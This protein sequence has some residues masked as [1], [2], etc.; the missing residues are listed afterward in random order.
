MI[1][2]QSILRS[3]CLVGA[4]LVACFLCA[5]AYGAQVDAPSE[6]KQ[7]EVSGEFEGEEASDEDTSDG[8]VVD[9]G[10]MEEDEY[11][12]DSDSYDEEGEPQWSRSQVSVVPVP[13]TVTEASVIDDAGN[14]PWYD[15]SSQSLLPAAV[16]RE[17]QPPTPWSWTWE[18]DSGSGSID[19][20]A[21][22][23]VVQVI[24]WMCLACL[25]VWLVVLWARYLARQDHKPSPAELER[26]RQRHEIDSIE[27]LPFQMAK[28]QSD[29][30]SEAR[31]HY[32]Q[33]DFREA[34]VYLFSY[35]LVQ[36]DRHQKIR[37]A[38]GKTNR[39]YLF[40]LR[41]Q[42]TLREIV[43]LSTHL[44]EDAFFGHYELDR[45]RFEQAWSK[46][47]EFD[48]VVQQEAP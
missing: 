28:P 21:L 30:L 38:K 43:R 8:E 2:T 35:Q 9:D 40:E 1:A 31:R 36:L 32:Q 44:F 17:P 47:E 42:P 6:D 11:L 33:G 24:V 4:L 27:Q 12:D 23:T 7:A 34:I 16:S 13:E 41:Q 5:N 46:L 3:W 14:F 26:A 37:L 18:W 10:A 45:Q 19:W 39:Q 22:W 48:R 25:L 15:P 20:S 29:L